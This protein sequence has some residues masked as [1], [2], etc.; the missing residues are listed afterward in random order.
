MPGEQFRLT[1]HGRLDAERS[2]IEREK[3]IQARMRKQS[4]EAVASGRPDL[5]L[6]LSRG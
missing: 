3:E 6:A 4:A 5:M 2:R 1:L